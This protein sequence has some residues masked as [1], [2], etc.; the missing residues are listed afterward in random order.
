MLVPHALAPIFSPHRMVAFHWK[1]FSDIIKTRWTNQGTK[2]YNISVM[3]ASPTTTNNCQKPPTT[4]NQ[5][6]INHPYE[7][8]QFEHMFLER[9]MFG[10]KKS[11]S[12]HLSIFCRKCGTLRRKDSC[13][14]VHGHGL[15]EHHKSILEFPVHQGAKIT[16]YSN[17]IYWNHV[18]PH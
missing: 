2:R 6:F 4:T 11:L 12:V 5:G 1:L 15:W 8:K 7:R 13:H 9:S 18:E 3:E 14:N 17:S 10:L 16:V